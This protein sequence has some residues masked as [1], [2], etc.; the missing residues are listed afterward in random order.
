VGGDWERGTPQ[1]GGY[2]GGTVPSGPAHQPRHQGL[3]AGGILRDASPTN[4]QWLQHLGGEIGGSAGRI[5]KGERRIDRYKTND[6]VTKRNKGG[7]GGSRPRG[8][9]EL[10]M[11]RERSSPRAQNGSSITISKWKKLLRNGTEEEN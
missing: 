1:K 8:A 7:G 3:K 10:S 6:T 11:D 2:R 9:K 4:T 5:E